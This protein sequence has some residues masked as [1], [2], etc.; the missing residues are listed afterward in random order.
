LDYLSIFAFEKKIQ[1]KNYNNNEIYELNILNLS[2]LPV[3]TP[4]LIMYKN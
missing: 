3:F 1:I 2:I 4:N